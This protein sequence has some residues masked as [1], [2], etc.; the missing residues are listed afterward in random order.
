MKKKNLLII[1]IIAILVLTLGGAFALWTYSKTLGNQ[2]LISGE[3]FLKYTEGDTI[4]IKEAMPSVTYNPDEYFEFSVEGKNKYSKDVIYEILLEEGDAPTGKENETRNVRIKPSLLKFRL[5]EVKD[6]VEEELIQEGSYDSIDGRRIWVDKVPANTTNQIKYTY[7]L[8]MWISS[9]AKIGNMEGADYTAEVWNNNVYASVKV[10]VNG[11]FNEKE[12]TEDY[13]I[14]NA[15]NESGEKYDLKQP[16][17]SDEDITITLGSKREVTKFVVSKS[18]EY[19]IAL[20]SL[21][22]ADGYT[23]SYNEATRTWEATITLDETG[24]YDYYA[25][26]P[27]NKGKSKTYSFTV[28]MNPDRFVKVEK[29]TSELC[30]QGL[31]YT[32]DAQDLIDESN[33]DKEGYTITQ[34]QGTDAKEYEVKAHLKEKFRWSDSSQEDTTFNCTIGPKETVLTYEPETKLSVAK[35]TKKTLTI[36]ASVEGIFEVNSKAEGTASVTY[37]PSSGTS[38]TITV[39]GEEEGSTSLDVKFTPSNNNYTEISDTYSIEVVKPAVTKLKENLGTGGLIGVTTDNESTIDKE[40]GNIREYRYSGAEV[41]N[42]VYFNCSDTEVEQNADNCETWRII[43]IFKD[44][45]GKENMKIVRN[46]ITTEMK[47]DNSLA[48]SNSTSGCKQSW[49]SSSV[50]PY[51]NESYLTSLTSKA[52]NMIEET[53]WYLGGVYVGASNGNAAVNLYTQERSGSTWTGKIGLMYPSD[54]GYS[55]DSSYWTTRTGNTGFKSTVVETSWLYKTA[56]RTDWGW[57]WFFS[58]YAGSS[59][60]VAS[61]TTGGYLD[62]FCVRNSDG[63]RPSLYLKSNVL[64]TSGNGSSSQ[65]YQLELN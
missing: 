23:A 28:L 24:I 61:W 62:Y 57:E 3:I 21:P 15:T 14:L 16:I 13:L 39:Q 30:K 8:Y 56:N 40:A 47:W 42:Y 54:Y 5:V 2:T 38:I 44:N 33:L 34:V 35:G 36:T 49:S 4:N 17:Q 53:K 46:S 31:T 51:L 10:G 63:V 60:S 50:R 45:S 32:G 59:D 27:E 64:I 43:G 52:Q 1:A 12:L 65:P 37:E 48:C 6:G 19:P 26:Y 20:T 41:N 29:P 58:P 18:S 11:D 25:V 9:N 7:R 22:N 55:V